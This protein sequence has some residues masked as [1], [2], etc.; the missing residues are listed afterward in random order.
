MREARREKIWEKA[1]ERLVSLPG[2]PPERAE[3]IGGWLADAFMPI[4]PWERGPDKAAKLAQRAVARR[5]LRE[6]I[7]SKLPI[8][9]P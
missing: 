4:F 1:A 8:S 9:L 3:V 2:Y 7:E 6:E 5:R